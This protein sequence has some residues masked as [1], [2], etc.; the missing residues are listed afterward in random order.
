MMI[1]ISMPNDGLVTFLYLLQWHCMRSSALGGGMDCVSLYSIAGWSFRL[2][3]KQMFNSHKIPLMA[4][5][6]PVSENMIYFL[7]S[8]SVFFPKYHWCPL[9]III[10]LFLPFMTDPPIITL[11]LSLLTQ[12]S[13]LLHLTHTVN[14][15]KIWLSYWVCTI[16]ADWWCL[17]ANHKYI[18]EKKAMKMLKTPR[19][20]TPP[21]IDTTSPLCPFPKQ[22]HP[23]CST[24]CLY[25][26]SECNPITIV[27][28]P[29]HSPG[30]WSVSSND[31]VICNSTTASPCWTSSQCTHDTTDI[32][33]S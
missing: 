16:K 2:C 1:Q 22:M 9:V 10:F 29:I 23:W 5:E 28:A 4:W 15:D 18:A 31:T 27:T 12:F 3:I 8:V 13:P 17:T 32:V 6:V 11:P 33:P 20:E 26:Q 19:H 25:C 30:L 24:Y 21:A 7:C 14:H